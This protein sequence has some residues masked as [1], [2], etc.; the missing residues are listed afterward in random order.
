MDTPRR[1]RGR[2]RGQLQ[3][4]LP[5]TG[6]RQPIGQCRRLL[7]RR[8]TNRKRGVVLR[9]MFAV[10]FFQ[11]SLGSH[12]RFKKFSSPP[13]SSS[14]ILPVSHLILYCKFQRGKK[15]QK[16]PLAVSWFRY[17]F[18]YVCIFYFYIFFP[19]VCCCSFYIYSYVYIYI[20][21]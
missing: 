17:F 16:K 3:Q 18:L 19:I 12:A 4:Q 2:T 7:V 11:H 5:A 9:C 20:Y 6:K 13:L 8:Q 15:K 21:I 1:D 10:A 14:F